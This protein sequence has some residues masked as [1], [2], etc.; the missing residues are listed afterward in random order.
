MWNINSRITNNLVE[1]YGR[2]TNTNKKMAAPY[3][4]KPHFKVKYEQK[5]KS[6]EQ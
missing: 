4:W 2:E 5:E 1:E 6:N 3:H